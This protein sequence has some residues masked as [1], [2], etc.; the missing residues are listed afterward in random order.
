MNE[1]TAILDACVLYPAPLRDLFMH[2]ALLDTFRARWTEE[3][4]EEWIRNVLE[5]RPDLR[6]E[7]LER[8][9]ELMNAHVRDC[10]VEN[11]EG[12]IGSLELP[13]AD[14]RHVLA[15]AIRVN[16]EL[17][18]TFNL[19][20]FPEKSL[21]PYNVAAIHP[22]I[23]VESLIETNPEAVHLAATRQWQSLRNP[24]KSLDEFLETLENNGL[25]KTVERLRI[26]F[27][28]EK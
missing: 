11:Y 6:R 3:I 4:H 20:D 7:Q 18:V 5:S 27:D 13:D 17:I 26:F 1:T 8:T 10:L 12:L 2:L 21:E 19:K 28:D 25:K 16:A 9:R 14:D 24:P 23:F 15:A 22:D